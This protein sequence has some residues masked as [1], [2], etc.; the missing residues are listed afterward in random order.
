MRVYL[1]RHAS[2][3]LLGHVLCGRAIDTGLDAEGRREAVV[4]ANYFASQRIDTLQCSPRR[5]ALETARPI[6]ESTGCDVQ[7]V[8]GLD[9]HDAAEWSCCHFEMLA[10]DAR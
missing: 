7:I 4:L 3:S 1:V 2:H 10:A 5:R 8:R 9:E 6:S